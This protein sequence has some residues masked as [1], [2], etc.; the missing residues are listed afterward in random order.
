MVLVVGHDCGDNHVITT[1]TVAV[2]DGGNNIADPVQKE[3]SNPD[4]SCC[5]GNMTPNPPRA[6]QYRVTSLPLDAYSEAALCRV[7]AQA[8]WKMQLDKAMLPSH[9]PAVSGWWGCC[10][11]SW[12]GFV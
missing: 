8:I 6:Y 10:W 5:E 4:D 12:L 7:Q 1:T 3:A 2:Q 11:I 9:E